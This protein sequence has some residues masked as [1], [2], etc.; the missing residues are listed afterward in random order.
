MEDTYGF[1][2]SGG[3]I[4][5]KGYSSLNDGDAICSLEAAATQED[6]SVITFDMHL[7]K[8]DIKALLEF[9]SKSLAIFEIE[10]DEKSDDIP[11]VDDVD[12]ELT[13]NYDFSWES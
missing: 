3:K 2:F 7:K 10:I 8:N 13:V 6:N 12:V 4:N 5:I 11:E 9:L 1:G